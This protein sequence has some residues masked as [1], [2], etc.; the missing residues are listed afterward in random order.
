MKN[1]F[2]QMLFTK[3]KPIL[4]GTYF[5]IHLFPFTRVKPDAPEF[6]YYV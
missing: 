6:L 3:M 2:R 5:L 1:M 4:C